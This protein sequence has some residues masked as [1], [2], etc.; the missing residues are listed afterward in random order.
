MKVRII[1]P[2]YTFEA[3]DLDKKVSIFCP[4]ICDIMDKKT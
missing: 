3:A 4:F 1:Q 2:F